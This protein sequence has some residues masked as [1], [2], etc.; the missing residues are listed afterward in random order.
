MLSEASSKHAKQIT[1]LRKRVLLSL[2]F[3]ELIIFSFACYL[4]IPVVLPSMEL[5]SNLGRNSISLILEI[6]LLLFSLLVALSQIFIAIF[7]LEKKV[8]AKQITWLM[9]IG[10]ILV[11]L[12]IP[13]FIFFVL[14]PIRETLLSIQ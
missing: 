4:F 13:G 8:G 11:V 7:S 6:G 2:G 3:S 1:K 14:D 9:R 5:Q 12:T 10:I